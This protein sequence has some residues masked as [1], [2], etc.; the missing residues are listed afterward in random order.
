MTLSQVQINQM[1]YTRHITAVDLQIEPH[2][3]LRKLLPTLPL[4]PSLHSILQQLILTFS[5]HLRLHPHPLPLPPIPPTILGLHFRL[6]V[7]W[8]R[9]V[10]ALEA[11]ILIYVRNGLL[12]TTCWMCMSLRARS[13]KWRSGLMPFLKRCPNWN[14]V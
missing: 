10:E 3:P 1:L 4:S 6:Q 11:V 2:L 9:I 5:L 14:C 8:V 13:R 12:L 7:V